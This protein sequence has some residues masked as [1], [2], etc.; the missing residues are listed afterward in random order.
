MKYYKLDNTKITEAKNTDPLDC[1][2]AD[3]TFSFYVSESDEELVAPFEEV[4]K[5]KLP[6]EAVEQMQESLRGFKDK[7]L[8]EALSLTGSITTFKSG[9]LGEEFIYDM[10]EQ[11]QI[12]LS[13]ARE[14]LSLMPEG[15]VVQIRC[16]DSNGVKDNRSHTKEQVNQLFEEWYA[17]K[18]AILNAYSTL[19][20]ELENALT[21]G[22]AELAFEVFTNSFDA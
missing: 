7:V 10:G 9:V 14:Y 5:E 1:V 2:F 22:E 13:Q 12:N 17:T 20:I 15:K 4:E 21:K 11:D 8:G 6:T 3:G 16:T 19:K 18:N